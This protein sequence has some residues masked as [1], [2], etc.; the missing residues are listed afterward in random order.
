MRA[1]I[2]T[3]GLN[4]RDEPEDDAR[5]DGDQQRETERH[6][7]DMQLVQAR[8]VG[9][10]EGNQGQEGEGCHA[11]PGGP[12]DASQDEA[13]GED[14]T[15]DPA[16]ASAEREADGQFAAARGTA[17][18][19]EV[20]HVHDRDEQDEGHCPEEHQQGSTYPSY[21]GLPQGLQRDAHALIRAGVRFFQAVRDAVDLALGTRQAHS[22]GEP[23]DY[24][25][26]ERSA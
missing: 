6:G 9:R 23:P 2:D 14:L 13:I 1:R 25:E 12:A 17:G 16:P 4:R 15:H 7:V 20:R 19:E 21:Q 8:Q 3:A 11:G 10:T 22:L 18:Q 5:A 26:P 24:W